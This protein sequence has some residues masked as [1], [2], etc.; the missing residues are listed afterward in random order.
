[1]EC[2]TARSAHHDPT[3]IYF[4]G[5]ALVSVCIYR[6]GKIAGGTEKR[7]SISL[8]PEKI[9]NVLLRIKFCKNRCAMHVLFKWESMQNCTATEAEETSRQ[10]CWSTEKF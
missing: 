4:P 10:K 2:M 7:H 1:M 5:C 3:L 6:S 9:R 8:P